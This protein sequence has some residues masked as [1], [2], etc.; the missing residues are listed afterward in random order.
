MSLF[1]NSDRE[2]KRRLKK[3]R[4]LNEKSVFKKFKNKDKILLIRKKSPL[5]TILKT[6][7]IVFL[8]I[9]GVCIS[10]AGYVVVSVY[11]VWESKKAESMKKMAEYYQVIVVRGAEKKIRY[12]NPMNPFANSPPTRIYDRNNIL[13]GE[14][15]P[16]YYEVVNPED[17]SPILEKTL[18]LMEDQKFYEHSGVNYIRTIYLTIRT[19]ISREIVGGGSTITQQLAKILFTKS[20]KT[21][22]RK[23][24][25]MFAANEIERRYSK[26][27]ILAMYLNTVYLG[28]GNYGFE[29]AS[30]YYF[31][32]SLRECRTIEYAMLVGLL[33]NPSY[34]SPVHKPANARRKAVQIL[35]RLVGFSVID[36]DNARKELIAFDKDYSN[37]KGNVVATQ[38][39]MTVNEAPYVNEYVRQILSRYFEK[40]EL[41]ISGLRIHTT[42]D[43][44]HYKQAER[45]LSSAVA[46]LQSDTGN[47]SF[48]GAV[49]SVEPTTGAIISL[50]G[51]DG[52]RLDNQFNRAT[53]ARR[54][55]GSCVKPFIYAYAFEGG[56]MPFSVVEDKAYSYPQGIGK[57]TWTPKNYGGKHKG[58]MR[59]DD[60]L[61]QS[62]NT[63]AVKM[64]QEIGLTYFYN[65]MKP[66][67]GPKGYIP[68]DLSIGLGTIELTPLEL[69]RA[70]GGLA[71]YGTMYEP[72]I[73]EYIIGADG[74]KMDL[75]PIVNK[76]VTKVTSLSPDSIYFVNTSLQK[77]LEPGGTGY[78]SA[79][80]MKF[81]Y[82]FSAKSGTTSDHRDAWFVVYSDKLVTVTW[83]GSD[84]NDELPQN[85]TGGALSARI[86][87]GY[88]NSVLPKTLQN[89][90][91]TAPYNVAVIEICNSSG[92]PRNKTCKNTTS[93]MLSG[94]DPTLMC[95]IDHYT[96]GKISGSGEYNQKDIDEFNSMTN[97]SYVNEEITDP[98]EGLIIN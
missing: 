67:V 17:I 68:K 86:A 10:L 88:L 30:R 18:L 4:A 60:A 47:R 98:T 55:I 59:L 39:K 90:S 83:I 43:V 87:F 7:I 33:P 25:E 35:N 48:Q 81:K 57:K 89:F 40:D 63:I 50:I 16:P 95:T 79:E 21:I 42:V 78:R 97:I 61:A 85:L 11:R 84:R 31:Q 92:L 37:M 9:S 1:D 52:Y 5:K 65:N 28:D 27:E 93:I 22:D 14:Y 23:L 96:G 76:S 41:S 3:M 49:V 70:F 53:S 36:A 24:F 19:I 38:W 29:A 15:M 46:Q 34:Y 72:Y 20:E 74:K 80:A 6:L 66:F 75:S 13:I 82:P 56:E 12:F 91:W 45:S 26:K 94:I 8:I 71:D 62:V 64:L 54:Q 32:K 51:G 2:I 58:N 44:K 73:I 69:A 77:V